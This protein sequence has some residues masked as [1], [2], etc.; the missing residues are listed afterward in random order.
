MTKLSEPKVDPI[1]ALIE[2]HKAACS[3]FRGTTEVIG[4]MSPRD[5]PL[6]GR[7]DRRCPSWEA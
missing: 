2:K 1:F 7:G 3:V 5:P 4:D 6:Q